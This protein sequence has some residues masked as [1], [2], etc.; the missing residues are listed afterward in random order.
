TDGIQEDIQASLAKVSDLKVTSRASVAR[1]REANRNIREIGRALQV[2][3][4]LEGSVQKTQGHVRVYGRLTDTRNGAQLWAEQ[5]DRA[6]D[7]LF[8]IQNEITRSIVGQMK[9]A[10]S[11]QEQAALQEKP[12][13]NM[14]AYDLYLQAREIE[15]NSFNGMGETTREIVLLDEATTR[16][17]AFVPALCLLARSHLDLYWLNLDHTPTRLLLAKKA[18]D[19]A[20]QSQPDAGEVHLATAILYYWG[21][22]D[23]RRALEELAIARRQLPNDPD[24]LVFTVGIEKRQGHWEEARRVC[25]QAI[26]LDPLNPGSLRDYSRSIYVS[27]RLYAE[28]GKLL[29]TVLSWK[30]ND[31]GLQRS[32]AYIAIA[33]KADLGPLQSV[34]SGESARTADPNLLADTRL[35]LA[36]W[37]RD[38]AAAERALADYRLEDSSAGG[39]V[40]PRQWYEGVVARNRGDKDAAQNAFT[41]AHERVAARLHNRPDDAK[42]LIM[43][44]EIDAALGHKDEAITEG[45]R[46]IELLPVS[47]DAADGPTILGGMASVYAQLGETKAALDLLDSCAS[48]PNGPDFGSL[49]LNQEWDSLRGD[50][51]F[52]K[53]VALA[54]APPRLN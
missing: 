31:F 52:D 7:D 5:Y 29:D 50:P 33:S 19:A 35:E 18:L 14:V 53:I 28:A 16:D 4:I 40:T 13:K 8:A 30:P 2:A 32:R 21:S 24:V 47:K 20:T 54:S 38:Y 43:L 1:Y 17:P 44:A 10:L 39:F 46:A 41:L 42:A 12:T 49:K 11:P 25:E 9:A 23:Y 6:V 45:R 51:R 36:L 48:M 27:M 34:V 3:H 26:A 15:R 22:R 37:R